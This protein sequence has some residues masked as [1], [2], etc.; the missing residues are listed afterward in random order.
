[1][2][3]A[4][5]TNYRPMFEEDL[6][7]LSD[8]FRPAAQRQVSYERLDQTIT[9]LGS[10][11]RREPVHLIPVSET[12]FDATSPL[13]STIRQQSPPWSGRLPDNIVPI[14]DFRRE[15]PRR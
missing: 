5:H 15:V 11:V 2:P 14:D 10:P 12:R 4:V 7:V 9:P 13:A 1:M 3:S 8:P 6:P